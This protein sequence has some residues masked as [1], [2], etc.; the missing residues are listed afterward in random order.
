MGEVV[1]PGVTQDCILKLWQ[2][3]TGQREPD[4]DQGQ[5]RRVVEGLT[6][7]AAASAVNEL[8]NPLRR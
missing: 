8:L 1:R 2:E 6:P 4:G 3:M 7:Q 5:R